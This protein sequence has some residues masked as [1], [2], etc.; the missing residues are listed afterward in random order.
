[1]SLGTR[2]KGSVLFLYFI[3]K[4]FCSPEQ[5]R[6]RA[7]SLIIF[8]EIE[9]GSY[10]YDLS[11]R[12]MLWLLFFEPTT[13]LVA[14]YVGRNKVDNFQFERNKAIVAFAPE[15]ES[16]SAFPLQGWT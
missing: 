14:F 16:F 6:Y 3:F 13:H 2:W 10:P 15:N 4:I 9:D 8:V 11:R 12:I 1:M 7:N 5:T